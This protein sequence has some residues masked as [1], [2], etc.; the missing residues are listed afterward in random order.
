M[1][2]ADAPVIC[3]L[4]SQAAPVPPRFARVMTSAIAQVIGISLALA[5]LVGCTPTAF[6]GSCSAL[7]DPNP[8]ACEGCPQTAGA[9][10]CVFN[11]C[12]VTGD[13]NAEISADI[14]IDRAL[15]QS[16]TALTV[17]VIDARVGGCGDLDVLTEQRGVIEGNR[18]DLQGGTFHQDVRIG[19]APAG[20][21][22]IAVD[23]LDSSRTAIAHGC[24][25][26][27]VVDGP[28]NVGVISVD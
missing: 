26:Q 1:T 15:G 23:G 12:E 22:I 10:I 19:N 17:A 18:V 21:V 27:S 7:C 13:K 3:I 11:S 6:E 9:Q 2:A 16:V 4:P 8:P 25:E 14:N 5:V 24:I 28:Q 20:D